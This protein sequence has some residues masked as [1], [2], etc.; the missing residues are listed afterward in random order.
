MGRLLQTRVQPG[1][2]H[3]P[4]TTWALQIHRKPKTT[5][6]MLNSMMRTKCMRKRKK[7]GYRMEITQGKVSVTVLR[8]NYY[9][10]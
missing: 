6:M 2:L 4:L 1:S 9:S 8:L 7:S 3:T 10:R 5:E